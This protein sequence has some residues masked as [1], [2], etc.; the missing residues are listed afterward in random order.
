MA[1]EYIE[2]IISKSSNSRPSSSSDTRYFLP[3]IFNFQDYSGPLE[4]DDIDESLPALKR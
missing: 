2:H 4:D 1:G 3:H